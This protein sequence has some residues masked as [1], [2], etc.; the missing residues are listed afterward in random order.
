MNYILDSKQMAYFDKNTTE[1]HGVPSM[2]LM[3][4]AALSV[5]E[6]VMEVYDRR[7]VK[8][9]CLCG[10]GNNGA[11]GVAIARLLHLAGY[12]VAVL[13]LGKPEKFSSQMNQQIA[14][15][16]SYGLEILEADDG[17]ELSKLASIDQASLIIDA[18]FGIGLSR[19][20]EGVYKTAI[21][22]INGADAF[23]IA[24]DIPSGFSADSGKVLGLGVQAD[25]T[26][27]FGYMKKGL[28]LSDCSLSC[29]Q[30][31]LMDVGIYV[32][33][34]MENQLSCYIDQEAEGYLPQRPKNANKGS[35]GKILI[36]AGSR[37]IYGACYL[38]AKAALAAG[39]GLVKIYT[40]ENNIASI[41][42][43]LPEA[44]YAG[45]SSYKEEEIKSLL[46]W[47]DAVLIGPGLGTETLSQQI[48]TTVLKYDKAPMVIDADGLNILSRNLKLLDDMAEKK[49]PVILTPHLK[50]MERLTGIDLSIIND[51]MEQTAI[52]F[53]EKH[54]CTLVLKNYTTLIADS[55]GRTY[56]SD[57]GNQALATPGSG[58]VLAGITVSM[59][60]QKQN[61]VLSAILGVYLHGRAGCRA[62]EEYGM[63]GVLASHI[64][65]NM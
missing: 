13:V 31:E 63:Q 50:E 2:V 32:E 36:I 6:Y 60:G 29:G 52:D 33:P 5:A 61:S 23:K 15:A 65:E 26:I 4:K 28:L 45:Y 37:S 54:P 64:I 3:E 12:D 59:L 41:Q 47:A 17:E 10:P 25:T 14:I 39:S 20:V 8:V 38:S 19:P 7:S 40:H 27:T 57:I 35:Q 24:A 42:Q 44:M 46:D 1:K 51:T 56:F 58:D 16:R 11:D 18:I 55:E 62:S 21:E 30:I 43:A 53:V 9:A 48:F 22:Q 34:E 49:I